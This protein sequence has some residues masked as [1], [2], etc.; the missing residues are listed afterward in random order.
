MSVQR[1]AKTRG[2]MKFI[3]FDKL[4]ASVRQGGA[5]VCREARPKRALAINGRQV[6][7]IR[8]IKTIRR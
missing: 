6:K 4:V 2:R 7:R 3:L 5:I 8:P 1:V